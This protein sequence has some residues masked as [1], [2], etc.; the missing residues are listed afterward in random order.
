MCYYCYKPGHVRRD[1]RKLQNRN[2]RP[3][4]THVAVASHVLEQSVV[5]SIDEYAKFS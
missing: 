1:C 4:S 5:L 2:Q 3:Q